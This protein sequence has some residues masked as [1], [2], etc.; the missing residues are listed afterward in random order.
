MSQTVR[1]LQACPSDEEID[2]VRLV[3]CVIIDA[4]K[5]SYLC[6]TVCGHRTCN[7]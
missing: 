3:D 2:V 5:S 1:F 6:L 7:L 4:V